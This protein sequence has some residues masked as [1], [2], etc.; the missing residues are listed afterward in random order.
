M[1]QGTAYCPRTRVALLPS[2]KKITEEMGSAVCR[3]ESYSGGENVLIRNPAT[4]SYEIPVL[5]RF[6]CR[7]IAS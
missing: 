1:Q 4:G 6:F 2:D 5:L 3:L 7:A